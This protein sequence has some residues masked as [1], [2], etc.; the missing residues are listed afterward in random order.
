M[1]CLD[2]RFLQ[3]FYASLA[4]KVTLNMLGTGTDHG[5]IY[6]DSFKVLCENW[7]VNCELN[8]QPLYT[9]DT[10]PTKLCIVSVLLSGAMSGLGQAYCS[11]CKRINP[12]HEYGRCELVKC[13]MSKEF[14]HSSF[15]CENGTCW[16]FGSKDHFNSACPKNCIIC[17]L[18]CSWH[19]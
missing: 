14:G 3:K 18:C 10:R 9:L 6:R 1:V 13:T 2:I 4:F 11:K 19:K 12:G 17:Y 16:T 7:T 15:Q 8:K 5:N